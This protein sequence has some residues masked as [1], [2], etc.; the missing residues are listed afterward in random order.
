MVRLA[1]SPLLPQSRAS[2]CILRRLTPAPGC[3]LNRDSVLTFCRL[4][5]P[6]KTDIALLK[7]TVAVTVTVT[8]RER[9]EPKHQN[10]CG[11]GSGVVYFPSVWPQP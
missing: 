10:M 7:V 8:E 2:N 5:L 4:V 11:N 6:E 3:H 9:R 1:C